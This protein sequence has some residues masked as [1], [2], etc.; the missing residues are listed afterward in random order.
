MKITIKLGGSVLTGNQIDV[1]FV[2]KFALMLNSWKDKNEIAVVVGAGKLSREFDKIARGLTS[3][4]NLLDQIGIYVARLNASIL[5]AALGESACPEIPRNETE[6][7]KLVDKYPGKIIVAG[8]FRPGQRTDAVAVEIA[9]D[10]GADLIIKGTDVDYVYDKDPDK[11]SDAK[12]IKELSFEE[13]QK[14]GDQEHV[15]NKPTIID[16]VAAKILVEKKIKLAIVNGKNLENIDRL[17]NGKEFIGTR[18][19]F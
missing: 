5:I 6:F 18:I 8:G 9:K 14:L 4:E 13:L 16:N 3:N 12:P 19:G 7:L 2:K 17:I 1:E 15:A 10:W 11:F